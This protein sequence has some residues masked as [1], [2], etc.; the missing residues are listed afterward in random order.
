MKIY[1][2]WVAD[3]KERGIPTIMYKCPHCL[4]SIVTC[5]APAGEKWDTLSSCPHCDQTHMKLT[6]GANA[7]GVLPRGVVPSWVKTHLKGRLADPSTTGLTA[8]VEE[9][10]PWLVHPRSRCQH[11]SYLHGESP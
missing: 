11:G 5:K 6:D 7:K 10:P 9:E 8:W 3:M 1:S 4:G 2:Q